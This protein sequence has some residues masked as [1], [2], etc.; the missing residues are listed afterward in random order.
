MKIEIDCRTV[1]MLKEKAEA[2]GLELQEM[3]EQFAKGKLQ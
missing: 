3:L 2:L 1:K